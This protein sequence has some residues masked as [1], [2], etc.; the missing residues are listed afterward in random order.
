MHQKT[1]FS[2][3]PSKRA[4]V[5]SRGCKPTEIMNQKFFKPHRGDRIIA[6]NVPPRRGS[7]TT[8][9]QTVG[10]RPRLISNAPNGAEKTVIIYIRS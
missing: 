6:I 10:L 4:I 5:F 9:H 1:D 7:Y 2:M 3:K 8:H